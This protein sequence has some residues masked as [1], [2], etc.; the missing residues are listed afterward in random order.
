VENR[1]LYIYRGSEHLNKGLGKMDIIN[2]LIEILKEVSDLQADNETLKEWNLK[3][4]QTCQQLRGE[5]REL[6]LK[7]Y[8]TTEE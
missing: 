3:L 8:L 5:N 1:V 6:R 4:A 2:S 7:N